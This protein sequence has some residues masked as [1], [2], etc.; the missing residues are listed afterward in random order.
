[1][2]LLVVMPLFHVMTYVVFINHFGIE[3]VL[4]SLYLTKFDLTKDLLLDAFFIA[5]F[6][7]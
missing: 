7:T 2:S 6:H 4:C 1:M 3:L 5:V